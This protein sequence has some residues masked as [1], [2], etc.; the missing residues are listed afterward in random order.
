MFVRLFVEACQLSVHLPSQ[1]I[2]V[3]LVGQSGL[4]EASQHGDVEVDVL[5]RVETSAPICTSSRSK[6]R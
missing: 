6:T 3:G 1:A 2:A 5:L 4:G